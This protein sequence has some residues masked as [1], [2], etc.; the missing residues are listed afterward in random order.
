MTA[1]GPPGDAYRALVTRLLLAARAGLPLVSFLEEITGTLLEATRSGAVVIRLERV[2]PR[3]RCRA[4]RPRGGPFRFVTDPPAPASPP[5]S[6]DHSPQARL[7]RA[8]L[9]GRTG[10]P[11]HFTAG[12]AF[13][14]G[15]LPRETRGVDVPGEG[16]L[17]LASWAVA[18]GFRSVAL[19]PLRADADTFGLLQ[20]IGERPGLFDDADLPFL[21]DVAAAVALAILHHRAQWAVQERVKELTCLY[22]IATI[23]GRADAPLDELLPG[24]VA[25][26]PP[27]WQYPER[28]AA[29]MTLDGR[30]YETAGF[31]AG[32]V[33]QTA[34]VAV[35]GVVRGRLDVVY[36]ASFPEMDEGP[37]LAEER[38]LIN[39][40]AHQLGLAIERREADAEQ[41]RLQEQLRH[42]DRL[43][44]LGRMTAGAAHELNE[45]LGA[46]L[47]FAELALRAGGVPPAAAAD[48][49][50]IVRATLHAREVV[51]KMMFFGRQTP[52][53]RVPVDLHLVVE[54]ALSFLGRRLASQA[55]AVVRAF[56]PAPVRIAGDPGQLQQVVVN[57]VVNAIQAMPEGGTL[58]VRTGSG[59]DGVTLAVADTGVGMTSE[60]LGRVFEP[61]FTTKD[62][63]QG[64]GLGLA[65]VHGI[66][67]AHGGT[68][69]AASEPGRGACFTARFPLT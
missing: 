17:D 7:C 39:E 11:E 19:I 65:V 54:E 30:T 68:I 42:V 14:A 64:T 45:P 9:A 20:L 37:F 24:I 63:G 18:G 53:R 6:G 51:K 61:F 2:L 35:R 8:L 25:L 16:T 22:G 32:D 10:G 12:G 1:P 40:I 4:I 46:I 67:A 28:C 58:T 47:G 31:V 59:P 13:V 66:V 52:P 27:G 60:V 36:T 33:R 41:T 44:T 15:D 34:A 49:D 50:R 3:V 23:A 29:R 55:V 48:L 38:S 69:E 5:G 56:A 21:E 26:V 43:A 62:E 57:L